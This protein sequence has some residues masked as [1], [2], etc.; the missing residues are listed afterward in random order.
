MRVCVKH[1][2]KASVTLVDNRQGT[3][4]DLC[5]KCFDK[6]AGILYDPVELSATEAAKVSEVKRGRKRS[7]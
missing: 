4:Y 1:K 5:P 6:M 2:D 7:A 3:E